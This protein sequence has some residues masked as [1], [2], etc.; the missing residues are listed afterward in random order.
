MTEK[1]K[2]LWDFYGADALE[3]AKHHEIHLRDFLTMENKTN[4]CGYEKLNENHSVAYL[5]VSKSEMLF[6]RDTL[7]PHRG[8]IYP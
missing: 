5:I 2:L 4:D 3:Y 7:K 8:E 6:F 1:L